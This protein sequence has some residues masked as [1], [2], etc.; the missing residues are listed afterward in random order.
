M[1]SEK[2]SALIGGYGSG[3]RWRKKRTADACRA[4]DTADL[5]RRG[6][7]AAGTRV[8]ELT[9]PAVLPWQKASTVTCDV[10]VGEADGSLRLRY[11]PARD[12][13]ATL[14][15]R[16]P[17]VATPCRLGGRRWFVCP[18]ARGEVACDRRVRKVFLVGRYFGCRHC[19]DLTYR[20]RQRSDARAYALARRG[21]DA[22]RPARW[23]TPA[24][25]GVMMKALTILKKRYARP[26]R[27]K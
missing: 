21:V 12:P 18:L 10:T 20:S 9:W 3:Q 25:L 23:K 19:H 22:I 17:L 27:W 2:R 26:L 4:I 11:T 14:D 24:D 15:Y 13:D 1:I 16:V 7:L 5:R 6:W 8:G